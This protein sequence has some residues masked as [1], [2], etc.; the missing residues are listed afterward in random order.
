MA[1][2][3]VTNKS[4][5]NVETG[6]EAAKEKTLAEKQAERELRAA[7]LNQKDELRDITKNLLAGHNSTQEQFDKLTKV[8]AAIKKILSDSSE[9]PASE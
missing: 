1:T 6:K 5:T 4:T 7:V 8:N 9:T 3:P 2:K